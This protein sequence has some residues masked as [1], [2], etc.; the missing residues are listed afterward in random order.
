MFPK[1]DLMWI[2]DCL[3]QRVDENFKKFRRYSEADMNSFLIVK[4]IKFVYWYKFL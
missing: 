2:R 4:K 3:Q 1:E